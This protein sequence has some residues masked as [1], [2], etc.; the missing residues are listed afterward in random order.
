MDLA[1][2]LN[3]VF[4]KTIGKNTVNAA[5][6]LEGYGGSSGGGTFIVHLAT[7]GD[8]IRTEETCG[9]VIDAIDSGKIVYLFVSNY[10]DGVESSFIH[11]LKKDY[12]YDDP[13]DSLFNTKYEFYFGDDNSAL[14]ANSLDQF[15]GEGVI[16]NH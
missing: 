10:G 2:A 13:H 8:F 6:L 3:R 14:V 9:E 11:S 1:E 12:V 5:E 16:E 4:E 15:L 7:N